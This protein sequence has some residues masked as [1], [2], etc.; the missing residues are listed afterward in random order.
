MEQQTVELNIVWQVPADSIIIKKSEYSEL[1]GQSLKGKWWT[2]ADIKERTGHDYAWL[3]EN[4]FY[5]P[6]FEKILNIKNGGFVKYSK[7]TGS[8]W[9]MLAQPMSDFLEDHFPEIM[10]IK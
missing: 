6:H 4:I 10:S 7:G 2:M 5:Q 9:E 8:Y 1:K 3:T